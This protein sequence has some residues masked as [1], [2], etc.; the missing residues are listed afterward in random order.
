[1]NQKFW[2]GQMHSNH[3]FQP[4]PRT[5]RQAFGHSWKHEPHHLTPWVALLA[6]ACLLFV[7]FI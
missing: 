1:M 4:T 5:F 3:K 6:A 2:I 7:T